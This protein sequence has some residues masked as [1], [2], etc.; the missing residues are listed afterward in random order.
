MFTVLGESLVDI[1][2][3]DDGERRVFPGGSPANVAVGLARLG[4][5]VWLLTEIGED[6][7]GHI[8]RDHFD[9]NGVN[10]PVDGG[11]EASINASVLG[12]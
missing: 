8:L 2:V 5:P 11:L 4:S 9:A 3:T 1:V 10:L 7:F 6:A 12:F